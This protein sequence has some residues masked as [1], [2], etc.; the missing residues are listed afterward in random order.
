[1][2]SDGD[3]PVREINDERPKEKVR[4]SALEHCRF[5]AGQDECR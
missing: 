4:N 5:A 1:M 3:R 2:S